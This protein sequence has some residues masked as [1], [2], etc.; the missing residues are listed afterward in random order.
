MDLPV[1]YVG[2]LISVMYICRAIGTR[3]LPKILK[4]VEELDFAILLA[5]IQ[6]IASFIV[7]L[8]FIPLGI[9]GL[10]TRYLTDGFRQPYLNKL[11][12]EQIESKY[13]ATSLSAVALLTSIA[14]AIFTPLM[15]IGVDVV[16]ARGVIAVT[17]FV[18]LLVA[19]PLGIALKKK[20]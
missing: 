18:S 9:L 13:R 10:G 4:K 15:G 6:G 14:L 7:A 3:L 1:K 8:P 5:S 12:N 11:Q 2:I 20:A 19:V 16:G 17:G